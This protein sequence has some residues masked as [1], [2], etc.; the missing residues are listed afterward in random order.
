MAEARAVLPKQGTVVVNLLFCV[1]FAV[2]KRVL[3]ILVAMLVL[4][5]CGKRQPLVQSTFFDGVSFGNNKQAVLNRL[6]SQGF[7]D[8]A[9]GEQDA[10]FDSIPDAVGYILLKILTPPDT[11]GF[12][13]LG[14]RWGDVQLQLDDKGLFSLTLH[15]TTLPQ[16]EEAKRHA[17]LLATL[18]A[19]GYDMEPTVVGQSLVEGEATSIMGYR[20][21]D[22]SHVVQFHENT[23]PGGNSSISLTHSAL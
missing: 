14:E 9:S 16:A 15:S 4:V 2:M 22:G 12:L 19:Q 3:Y 20:Y 17:R 10:H 6:Y 21:S 18:K 1:I 8:A 13:F 7:V 23:T 11:A 5:A